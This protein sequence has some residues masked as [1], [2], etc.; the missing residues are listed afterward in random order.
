MLYFIMVSEPVFQCRSIAFDISILVVIISYLV[1][2]FK[3]KYSRIIKLIVT[4]FVTKW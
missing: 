3:Q 4:K 1:Q 2:K